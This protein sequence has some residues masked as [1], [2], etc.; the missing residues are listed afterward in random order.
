MIKCIL[1]VRKNIDVE[2]RILAYICKTHF[3]K[4]VEEWS[5]LVCVQIQLSAASK[6]TESEI[7]SS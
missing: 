3:T 5:I 4:I 6:D 2:L 1:Y 7:G